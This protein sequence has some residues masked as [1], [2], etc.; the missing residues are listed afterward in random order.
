MNR[1]AEDE[2]LDK[3][4]DEELIWEAEMIEHGLLSE[5]EIEERHMSKAEIDASFDKLVEKLKAEGVYREDEK[6]R[7]ESSERT[8]A[9]ISMEETGNSGKVIPMPERNADKDKGLKR[10]YGLGKVAGL[11]LVCILSVLGASMSIEGNRQYFIEKI[12]Y[13]MGN[14][15][16]IHIDSDFDVTVN[17]EQ[18]EQNAIATI[19]EVLG[20][21]M[22]I[23][24]Y[25]PH[26]FTFCEFEIEE[27]SETA[28]VEY[29][30]ND[31]ILTLFVDKKDKYGKKSN[32]SLDGKELGTIYSD[33]GDIQVKVMKIQDKNDEAPSYIATWNENDTFYQICGKMEETEFIK[34]IEKM[35]F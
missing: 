20:V 18:G 8:A 27:T 2:E 5:N 31:I 30:Y 9:A 14:D 32:L 22:P 19:E 4:L 3:L 1:R 17:E 16:Q 33:N 7:E 26:S 35:Q 12:D 11:G 23:F 34:L 6:P 25:R 29:E 10:R 28:L 13:F 15:T 24:R 21:K